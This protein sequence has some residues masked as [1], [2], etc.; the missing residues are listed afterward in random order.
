MVDTSHNLAASIARLCPPFLAYLL[1]LE[2]IMTKQIGLLAI[3]LV[4]F[5]TGQSWADW[6]GP[7][8]WEANKAKANQIEGRIKAIMV[9][10]DQNQIL[11]SLEP[12]DGPQH[13]Q[14]IK[15]CN[16]DFGSDVRNFQQSEK[17]ALLRQAFSRGDKVRVSYGSAFDRCLSS[18]SYSY[19]Q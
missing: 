17:M 19:R 12:A 14:T 11:V 5:L 18:I 15:V 1:L 2:G 9:N 4:G 7:T 8:I 13:V 3:V 10:E 6:S 16:Q